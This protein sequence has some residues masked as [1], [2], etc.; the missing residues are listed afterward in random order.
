[1][2]IRQNIYNVLERYQ[3]KVENWFSKLNFLMKV[4]VL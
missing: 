1:M 4:A 2:L 3:D